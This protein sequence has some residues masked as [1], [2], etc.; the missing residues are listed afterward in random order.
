MR[1]CV[2]TQL[3]PCVMA[4]DVEL[5]PE[6]SLPIGVQRVIDDVSVL[7]PPGVYGVPAIL[8][9]SCSL[10]NNWIMRRIVVF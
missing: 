4:D 7:K 5:G 10:V 3:I 1:C 2:N 9:S 6:E 8:L